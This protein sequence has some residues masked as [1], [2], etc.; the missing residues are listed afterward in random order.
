SLADVRYPVGWPLLAGSVRLLQ[1]IYHLNPA[2]KRRYND[3]FRHKYKNMTTI[4]SVR[5]GRQVA[6]GGDGQVTLGAIV[7][8]ASA[9][10]VRRL[11]HDKVLAGFAGGTAD[12]FTLFERFE[13]KLE[14]HQ[15]HLM[16]SAVELAK[17]W[18]TDRIL[19]RLEAM[20]V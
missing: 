6:L 4:V 10:K 17:D 20:L 2:A 16:R 12:A 7:A 1:S 9:R 14:K 13:A 18:R 11:Y 15:G 8:K 19:R 5:R 3:V